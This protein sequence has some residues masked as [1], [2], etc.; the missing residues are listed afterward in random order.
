VHIEV[1]KVND[2]RIEEVLL[3]LRSREEDQPSDEDVE[4]AA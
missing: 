4:E 3:T 1:L 2:N